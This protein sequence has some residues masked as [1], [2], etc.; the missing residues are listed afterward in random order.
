MSTSCPA[1]RK[2]LTASATAMGSRMAAVSVISIEMRSASNP[3]DST[4][5]VMIDTG[6][7]E[8]KSTR[9]ILMEI[10]TA[11]CPRPTHAAID[12]QACSTTNL[13]TL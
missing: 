13:S 6:S 1:A 12:E 8:V 11:S 10:G 3:K 4:H 2:R 7:F 5:D 9:E